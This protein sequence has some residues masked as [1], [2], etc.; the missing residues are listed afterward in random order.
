MV[1]VRSADS[2]HMIKQPLDQRDAV[3]GMSGNMNELEQHTGGQVL[4]RALATA[5][6]SPPLSPLR[7]SCTEKLLAQP[8][9]SRASHTYL[10]AFLRIPDLNSFWVICKSDVDLAT[11]VQI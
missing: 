7:S 2:S 6:D 9:H 4:S 1:V 3:T 8:P 11:C 5:S 10:P